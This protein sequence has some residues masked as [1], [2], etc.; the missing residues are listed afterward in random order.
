MKVAYFGSD[1][2]LGCLPV[3]AAHGHQIDTIYTA[4]DAQHHAILQNYAQ[5]HNIRCQ[6]QRPSAADIQNL[7]TRGVECLFA[8]QYDA[9]IPLPADDLITLNVHPTLLPHGRGATPLHHLI[10]QYPQYA[11]VTLHKLAERFDCG[12][13][14]LQSALSVECTESLESL[15]VKLDFRISSLLDELFS[16]WPALYQNARPQGAGSVWPKISLQDRLIDWQSRGQELDRLV[17]AFGR[18]G[19]IAC[20]GD[21]CWLVNHVE[22]HAADLAVKAGAILYED[23][24][25]RAIAIADG[26]VI[27]YKDSIL[28]TMPMATIQADSA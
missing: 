20:A 5:R 13:I 2:F 25:T 22:I 9:L 14:V 26:Y 27:I 1:L 8:N 21:E 11:G 6:H 17:R 4:G 7:L 12:D 19:V 23:S 3:F 18:F 24:R 10:L 16:H 15:I 28:E